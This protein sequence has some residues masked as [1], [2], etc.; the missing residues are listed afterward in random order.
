MFRTD[1]NPYTE[2]IASLNRASEAAAEAP[3]RMGA[4][5][6]QLTDE[7]R[8]QTLSMLDEIWSGMGELDPSDPNDAELLESGNQAA[9][10]L[11]G[12]LG[13][14]GT[15]AI[16]ALGQTQVPVT[17]QETQTVQ[18]PPLRVEG[19]GLN[20][21]PEVQVSSPVTRQQSLGQ[22]VGQVR[23][24]GQ[25]A[26]R[27][28]E[29]DLRE[30]EFEHDEF[31]TRLNFDLSALDREDQQEF[32]RLMTE[33]EQDFRRGMLSDELSHNMYQFLSNQ[34][35][36]GTQAELDRALQRELQDESIAANRSVVVEERL[37]EQAS[38]LYNDGSEQSQRDIAR[39]T[40]NLQRAVEAG[41]LTPGQADALALQAESQT[42]LKRETFLRSQAERELTEAAAEGERLRV[43]VEQDAYKLNTAEDIADG[44][45]AAAE[46]G[47]ISKIAMYENIVR[48]GTDGGF[49]DEQVQAAQQLNFGELYDRAEQVRTTNIEL[50]NMALEEAVLLLDE[51]R[52]SKS[53]AQLAFSESVA[54]YFDTL[55]DAEAYL[56]TI[57]P[58]QAAALGLDS[59]QGRRAFLASVDYSIKV[60]GQGR[61]AIMLDEM[62]NAPV[63]SD[64]WEQQYVNTALLAGFEDE[65]TARNVARGLRRMARNEDDLLEAQL[66]QTYAQTALMSAEQALMGTEGVPH[67]AFDENLDAL[68]SLLTS[69]RHNADLVCASVDRLGGEE[70]RTT[71]EDCEAAKKQVSYYQMAVETLIA[72][73]GNP[74]PGWGMEQ[75]GEA[76]REEIEADIRAAAAAGATYSEFPADT[77]ADFPEVFRELYPEA[78]LQGESVAT[79]GSLERVGERPE[80]PSRGPLTNIAR[81]VDSAASGLVR[82]FSGSSR[83]TKN[84]RDRFDRDIVGTNLYASLINNYANGVLGESEAS[85][86]AAE[87]Q[88]AEVAGVLGTNSSV[89]ETLLREHFE[90]G[91]P[92]VNSAPRITPVGR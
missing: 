55:E 43:R 57:P 90:S 86:A 65:A 68:Q 30:R 44:A 50:T 69:A 33:A 49:S 42:G 48:L 28:R 20:I 14:S 73:H 27:Q 63:D 82:T 26:A 56:D 89:V 45:M 53:E 54:N 59:E 39:F 18:G 84:E 70:P 10:K 8:Q 85:K 17:S 67:L 31:M 24:G 92:E 61:F 11:L 52:L 6:D 35:W 72:Q 46:A 76:T 88:L 87:R 71:S 34:G 23:A 25:R 9:Q 32:Q 81:S 66:A 1:R 4:R 3:L 16:Q 15:E 12:M 62:R 37:W 21:S 58:S 77:I 36:Q 78:A 5:Q 74:I 22:V 79:R 2:M 40:A 41:E 19:S 80:T 38:N 47:N 75:P 29:Q 13:M 64:E 91:T 7:M 51:R 60:R 83:P